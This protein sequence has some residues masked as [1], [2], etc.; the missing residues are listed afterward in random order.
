DFL[1]LP[2]THAMTYTLPLYIPLAVTAV[3]LAFAGLGVFLIQRRHRIKMALR[4]AFVAFLMA[5][6]VGGLMAPGMFMDRVTL[7]ERRLEQPHGIWFMA[8]YGPKGFDLAKVRSIQISERLH[9]GRRGR[10]SFQQIW[11]ATYADGSQEEVVAGDLW[12]YHGA[13][14]VARLR[15]RGIRVEDL[16]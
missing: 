2:V 5:A 1:S 12:K 13:E 10:S 11:T 15:A 8:D 9:T 14:I 4:L 16:R 7:D 6:M 3:A